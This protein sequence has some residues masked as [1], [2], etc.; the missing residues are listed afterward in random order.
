MPMGDS[1]PPLHQLIYVYSCLQRFV[2][3]KESLYFLL[4]HLPAFDQLVMASCFKIQ[5]IIYK[6]YKY[7]TRAYD[8][9]K[10]AGYSEAMNFW[11][12]HKLETNRCQRNDPTQNHCHLDGFLGNNKWVV[13]GKFDRYKSLAGH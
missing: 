6:Y 9:K 4:R 13:H 12:S 11:H 8:E 1:T 3:F 5:N 2:L 7:Y 10:E